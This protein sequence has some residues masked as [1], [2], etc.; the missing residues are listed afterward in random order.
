M[1][2]NCGRQRA[3][4]SSLRRDMST[5]SHG[6]MILTGDKEELETTCHSATLSTTN[7]TWTDNPG[8]R[9]ERP[10]NNRLSHHLNFVG[11]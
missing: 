3:Y 1:S 4:F 8:L 9:A 2:V 10:A 11:H 6:R 5:K 7:P